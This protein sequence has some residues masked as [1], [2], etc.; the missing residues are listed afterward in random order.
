MLNCSG[1]LHVFINNRALDFVP[2]FQKIFDLVFP[3]YKRYWHNDPSLK[4][5]NDD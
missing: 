2:I 4:E 1:E 3:V 5:K